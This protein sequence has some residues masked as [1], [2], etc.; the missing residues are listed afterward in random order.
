MGEEEMG[1]EREA[2]VEEG[3]GRGSEGARGSER[4]GGGWT[5]DRRRLWAARLTS[6]HFDQSVDQLSFDQSVDQLSL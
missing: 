6:C 3:R 2:G 4:R 1:E 5:G